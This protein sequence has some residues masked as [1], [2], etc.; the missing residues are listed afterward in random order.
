M[1]ILEIGL[2]VFRIMMWPGAYEGQ[3]VEHCG[4]NEKC[5]P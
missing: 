1:G 5:P 2:K 3:G 4:L